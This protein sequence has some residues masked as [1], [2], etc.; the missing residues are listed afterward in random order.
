MAHLSDGVGLLE[1]ALGYALA[2][3][4]AVTP[5]ALPRATPCRRWDLRALL[6]HLDDSLAALCEAVDDHS[7]NLEVA[8]RIAAGD[9]LDAVARCRDGARRVLGAWAGAGDR[10]RLVTVGGCPMRA[11]MVACVG[12]VEVAVHGWDVEQACGRPRPIP[13]ALA[14]ELL[15]IAPAFVTE[16]ERPSRFAAPAPVHPSAPA[17]DRLV[18]FLGRDPR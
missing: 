6:G 5:D 8:P 15:A 18:A 10:D 14:T 12:A 3:L 17:G 2:G 4:D 7:V 11:T 16:S 13:P 9:G 1:R